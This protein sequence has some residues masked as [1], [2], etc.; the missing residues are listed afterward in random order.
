MQIAIFIALVF[1]LLLATV[2]TII[3]VI[4]IRWFFTDDDDYYDDGDNDGFGEDHRV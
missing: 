1:I 3:S 2:R 4:W